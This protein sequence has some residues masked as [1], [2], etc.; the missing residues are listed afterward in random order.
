MYEGKSQE[1]QKLQRSQ[2][3]Q[4]EVVSQNCALKS[5]AE[6][7]E[8]RVAKLEQEKKEYLDTVLEYQS[9]CQ[10]VVLRARCEA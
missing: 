8:K 5:A 6:A 3:D 4:G 9:K 7:M 1:L 10:A 2:I